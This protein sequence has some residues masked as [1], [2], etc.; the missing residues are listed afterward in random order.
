VKN[1]LNFGCCGW[2]GGGAVGGV[3]GAVGGAVGGVDV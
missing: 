2:Q 3:V 1:L